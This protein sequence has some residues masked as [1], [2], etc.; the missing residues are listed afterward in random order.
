MDT[1]YFRFY[2]ELNDF[3]PLEKRQ[4]TVAYPFDGPVSVKHMIEAAG[5]PHTEVEL[6]LANGESVGFDYLVQAG[7]RIS[8]YPAFATI[9]VSPVARTY[10]APASAT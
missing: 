6:I 8:V 5:I 2:A 9:D 3:V 4:C 10:T 7:D 1:S